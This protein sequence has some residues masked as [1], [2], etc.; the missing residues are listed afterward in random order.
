MTISNGLRFSTFL[1]L[2]TALFAC[3][4]GRSATSQALTAS[5]EARFETAPLIETTAASLPSNA[6]KAAAT[7]VFVQL[8]G[9]PITVVKAQRGSLS[10]T[11][12]DAIRASLKS[13]QDA[14]RPQIEALGGQVLA[15]FQNSLNGLKVSI[16]SGQV[17]ALSG[18]PGVVAVLP[19]NKY[20]LNNTNGVP[21]IGAPQV[22]SAAGGNFHGEGIKIAILDTGIDYTHANFA[23]P[24]TAA[25]YAAAHAHETEP[26]DPALFGPNAP[27]VKGG[28][29]LVGDAYNASAPAG[30]PALIPHPDPNPLDCNGHGSHVA[31]TATGLGV[32]AAGATYTGSYDS[33]TIANN[34]WTI[35]PGVAPKA[36]LYSVRVFGC[37]GSTDVVDQAIEWAVDHDMDV[38]NMSLGSP[39]GTDSAGAAATNAAKAG[40]L[41]V[42]SAGNNGSNPYITGSPSTG[43]NVISVAAVDATPSFP[44]VSMALS[45]GKTVVA[46]N[47]NGVTS[48]PAGALPVIV[49]RDATQPGGISLGC[50]PAEYVAANVAGKVAV[51][52]RGTCA[53]VARAIYGQKAGAAAV[54]MINNAN[55][56]PP[57]EGEITSN[58]DT[59][60]A[61]TVTIPFL[62]INGTVTSTDGKNMIAADGGTTTLTATV[63]PN[64]TFRA[65]ASF[66]SGGPRLLD[67]FLKPDV[68]APGVS[69]M[70]TAVGTGNQGER[71]SGTSMAAPHTT[72]AAALTL[73]AHPGWP[74]DEVRAAL[75]N[76]TVPSLV[77]GYSTR[78][79]GGGLVQ[80]PGAVA[81]QATATTNTGTNLS[82][83]FEEIKADYA[84]EKPIKI[85]NRGSSAATF[86]ISVSN[87]Q[88]EAH[89][90][91]PS[92]TSITVP[93]GE[94]ATFTVTLS[95]PA[96]TVR[97]AAAF[98]QVAGIVNLTPDGGGNNGV[99][100]RV[101]YYLVPRGLSNVT[102]QMPRPPTAAN[103]NATVRLANV[104]GPIAGNAD[105]YALGIED[106]N[107]AK[108]SFDIRAVGVQ[109]FASPTASNPTR[110]LLVLA[111]NTWQR[112]S[113]A[114]QNEFDTYVDV[115]DDGVPDYVIVAVDFG[116][117]A[118]GTADGRFGVFIVDLVS[119]ALVSN[120]FLASAPTDGSTAEIPFYTSDLCRAGNKCFSTAHPHLT[121][122]T[123]GFDEVGSGGSDVAQGVGRYNPWTPA[124][125][126]GDFV[127]LAPNAT[128]TS[129]VSVN[130]A[131]WANTPAR[132]VMVVTTDNKSGANEAATLSFTLR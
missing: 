65:L 29:D 102:A 50:N 100:L 62:G 82:F 54:V 39:F 130:V 78:L 122:Q 113:T 52:Q 10:S 13:G 98:R 124:I 99:T 44:G 87:Q 81:T 73:Q 110:Q 53:R 93:P 117:V 85:R 6:V 11:D 14:V 126:Q 40:V 66:S 56:Y 46:I 22:W 47:A 59:G 63:I 21:L 96:A 118:T 132:G 60:E 116:A 3:N 111:V 106:R 7:T 120:G 27:K 127:P 103:P 80:V 9:D 88:G 34:A 37:A 18:I 105:F 26:A 2:G 12:K 86:A 71:L 5:P 32:T 51:V 77:A 112:W 42:A 121:Y 128:G 23:G 84:K 107:D 104:N 70:S 1:C 68:A 131:E 57:F 35:G 25:A 75:V 90:L 83:G 67:S 97:N 114:A 89:T 69:V 16:A 58:P 33:G 49:L 95:V 20:Q 19:V 28:T 36:D 74:S 31:G 91:T 55:T 72:G 45:T 79:A 48:L 24:G 38:I 92:V 41:V 129:A 115:D 64:P 30:S 8:K 4:A 43:D 61:Y 125:S 108:G 15:S 101:P 109:S 76:T 123:I 17:P 94:V 119:G